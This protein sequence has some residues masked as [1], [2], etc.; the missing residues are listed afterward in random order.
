MYFNDLI[1]PEDQY[2][3][4][5]V[6]PGKMKLFYACI[7]FYKLRFSFAREE[8]QT[9]SVCYKFYLSENDAN[10]DIERIE[11]DLNKI[12]SF[13]K[14][15]QK[16]NIALFDIRRDY[17]ITNDNLNEEK[18]KLMEILNKDYDKV[19]ARFLKNLEDL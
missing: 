11:D 7:R 13:L 15:S 2:E 17:P 5:F 3:D 10:K 18:I 12:K 14:N 16:I 8:G 9:T 19:F 4:E 1:Y 6:D